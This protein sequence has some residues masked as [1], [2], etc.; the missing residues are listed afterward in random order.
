LKGT[1][2]SKRLNALCIR[3]DQHHVVYSVVNISNMLQRQY[4]GKKGPNSQAQGNNRR[5]HL[6]PVE[7]N[8]LRPSAPLPRRNLQRERPPGWG[9]VRGSCSRESLSVVRPT[10]ENSSDISTPYLL[11]N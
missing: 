11:F 8:S 5:P 4:K 10:H 9:L 1:E 6:P 7:R 3:G 2:A